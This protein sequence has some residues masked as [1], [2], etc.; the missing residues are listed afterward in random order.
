VKRGVA[1]AGPFFGIATFAVQSTGHGRNLRLFCGYSP[2]STVTAWR[3][4]YRR[5]IHEG[6]RNFKERP[7]FAGGSRSTVR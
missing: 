3:V 4:L 6:T 7:T 2:P 1:G 5:A